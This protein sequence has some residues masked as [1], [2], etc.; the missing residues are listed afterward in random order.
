VQ[1]LPFPIGV[2]QVLGD[3]KMLNLDSELSNKEVNIANALGVPVEFIKGGLSYSSQGPALRLLENQ[4]AKNQ[5]DLNRIIKFIIDEVATL[6]NKKPIQVTLLPFKIIDDL[7]EKATIVQLASQGGGMISTGTLLELFNMDAN[8][9]RRRAAE[10]QKE[11]I[12]EQLDIQHY[13]QEVQQNIQEKARQENI[14]NQ[15]SFNSLN[16]QALMQEAQAQAQQLAQLSDGERKSALDE[17]AKTN[18]IMYSTVKALLEMN[19]RREIY[20][21]GKQAVDG[22]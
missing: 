17:M 6:V 12:K 21:A 19:Q 1:V 14:M 16:T 10:E 15:S 7:Q 2:Q 4:M 8:A 3:G 5:Y 9:E 18:Y 20:Q 13:Q 11:Q 22:Q